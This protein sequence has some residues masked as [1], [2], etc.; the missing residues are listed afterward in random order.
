MVA[1]KSMGCRRFISRIALFVLSSRQKTVHFIPT[2]LHKL[3]CNLIP[4]AHSGITNNFDF[5]I[6]NKKDILYI[7]DHHKLISL[8]MVSL[9]NIPID[10]TVE[11]ILRRWHYIEKNCSVLQDEFC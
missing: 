10:S 7:E 2:F 6:I 9:T 4:K 8:D 11:S 5:V 3:I 1:T